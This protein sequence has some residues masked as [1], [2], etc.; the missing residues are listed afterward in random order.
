LHVRKNAMSRRSKMQGCQRLPKCASTVWTG[1]RS[2]RR[3][4][5]SDVLRLLYVDEEVA[6]EDV[7]PFFV[8]LGLFV[9][10]VL[11]TQERGSVSRTGIREQNG[12]GME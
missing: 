2:G 1:W 4:L 5:Q 10:L 11:L 6:F 8:L 12:N 7:F 3:K 9:R